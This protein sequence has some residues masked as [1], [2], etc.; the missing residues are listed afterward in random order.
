MGALLTDILGYIWQVI[1]GTITQL[2]MLLGPLLLLAFIMHFVAKKNENLSYK[3]MGPKVYLYGFG[4]LGTAVHELGHAIFALIFRHKITKINLFNIKADNGQLGFVNHSYN[5]KSTYQRIGNFFIGI[6]PILFGSIL[7]Y[8]FSWLFFGFGYSKIAAYEFV[9]EDIFTWSNFGVIISTTWNNVWSYFGV[10]FAG[11]RSGFFKIL[12]FIYLLYSIG[13]SITLSKSDIK[14]SLDGFIYFVI[15]LFVFNLLS[16]WIGD[17][18]L[19]LIIDSL[20]LFSG[21]Y[22]ILILSILINLIFIG[23][24]S[25]IKVLKEKSI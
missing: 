4:W 16:S 23:I 12:L 13:S 9:T 1:L 7:L 24:L 15:S 14:G 10:V 19:W 21:F 20:V 5:P 3:V 25:L 11:P 8:F 22:F 2:F 6:G 17:F 18:M